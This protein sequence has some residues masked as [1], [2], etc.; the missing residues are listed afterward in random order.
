M[1]LFF[2]KEETRI[3]EY[4]LI[5]ISLEKMKAS[6]LLAVFATNQTVQQVFLDSRM[7]SCHPQGQNTTHV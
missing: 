2:P 7:D 4:L 5:F 1:L 3:S 6:K